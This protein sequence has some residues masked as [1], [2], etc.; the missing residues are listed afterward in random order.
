MQNNPRNTVQVAVTRYVNLE[1]GDVAEGTTLYGHPTKGTVVA[2]CNDG[3]V[4]ENQKRIPFG[5][6]T[7]VITATRQV[8]VERKKRLQAA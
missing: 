4:L 6:I 3:V 7:D 1:V 2:I 8:D 5:N